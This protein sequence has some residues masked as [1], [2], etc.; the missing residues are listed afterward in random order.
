MGFDTAAKHAAFAALLQSART[1]GLWATVTAYVVN[2]D[3]E[4]TFEAF[5]DPVGSAKWDIA[6]GR[7]WV[8][9]TLSVRER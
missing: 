4:V 1:S 9:L 2:L 8:V 6:N 7:R 3:A 5:L